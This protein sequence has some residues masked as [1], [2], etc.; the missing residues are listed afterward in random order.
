MVM[1]LKKYGSNGQVV[2]MD[3]YLNGKKMMSSTL[4]MESIK[5]VQEYVPCQSGDAQNMSFMDN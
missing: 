4:R 5:G 1:Q 3:L 2:G